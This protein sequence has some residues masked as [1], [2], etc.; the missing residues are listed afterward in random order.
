[1]NKVNV[2]AF[3]CV[4]IVASWQMVALSQSGAAP[5]I[6]CSRAATSTHCC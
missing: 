5:Q 2:T 6:A 1:M 3:I 4:G